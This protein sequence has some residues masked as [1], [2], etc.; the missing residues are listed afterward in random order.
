[1]AASRNPPAIRPYSETRGRRERDIVSFGVGKDFPHL[2]SGA[3]NGS[4]A[5]VVSAGLLVVGEELET[6]QIMRPNA[7]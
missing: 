7:K 4:R 6:L 3:H 2:Q 1:M 5:F